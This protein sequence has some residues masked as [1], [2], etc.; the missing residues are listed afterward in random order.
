[1]TSPTVQTAGAATLLRAFNFH[2]SFVRSD[3]GGD[4]EPLADGG[5]QECSGLSLES[6]IREYLEGGRNDAV[7]RRVGR[8]NCTDRPQARH[9]P[10]TRRR[11]GPATSVDLA[12]RHGERGASGTPL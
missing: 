11:P 6:D 5:F 2:V 7:V 10:S 8:V 12:D 3:G 4:P 1:M 9:A